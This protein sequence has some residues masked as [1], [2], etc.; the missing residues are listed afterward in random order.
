[1]TGMQHIPILY[2]C[3]SYESKSKE[4]IRDKKILLLCFMDKN[5]SESVTINESS[6]E[7]SESESVHKVST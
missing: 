7:E 6:T 2:V 1:M 3:E 4:I 5:E